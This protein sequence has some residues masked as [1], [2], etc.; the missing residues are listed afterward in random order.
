MSVNKSKFISITW[1]YTILFT[2]QCYAEHGYA[3]VSRLSV[4]L[5]V[6]VLI[7]VLVLA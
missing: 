5:S 1:T 7:Q 4:H 2:L 3:M 6:T